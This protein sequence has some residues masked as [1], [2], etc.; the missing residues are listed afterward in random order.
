MSRE[1]RLR[2]F[3]HLPLLEPDLDILPAPQRG[4]WQGLGDI[5][6]DFV[7]YGGTGLALRLG[8]RESLDFDFFSAA[9][10]VPPDLLRDLAWLGRVEMIE[11]APDTLTLRTA[12][13]MR[14]SFFGGMRLQRV[15]EPSVAT[16]NGLVVASIYDL[17]GTK[18]KAL[19]DRSEWRDY[20]DIATLLRAGHA[21]PDVIGYAST[22]FDPLFAF[23]VTLFLRSLVYF[24]DGT[25][26]D[27]P[28]SVRQE[29]EDA[30]VATEHAEIPLV[31]PYSRS[32]NP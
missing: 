24:E 15:A 31:E 28:T 13:G 26:P 17:A 25:A 19:L 10:F 2:R 9:P 7:L 22:I 8:H 20:V 3:A 18:A 27:V 6:D 30:V 4:L 32:I 1:G 21:L 5:P 16:D 11:S 23:P 14:L 12:G 29:L